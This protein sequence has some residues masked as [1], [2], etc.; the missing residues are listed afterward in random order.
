MLPQVEVASG[1]IY[2]AAKSSILG[3]S[4]RI[5]TSIELRSINTN[6]I[7]ARKEKAAA[8]LKVN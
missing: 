2:L 1:T 4:N 3:L 7:I 5:V 6:H 8:K